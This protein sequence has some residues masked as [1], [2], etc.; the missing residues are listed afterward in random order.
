MDEVKALLE[1]AR[2]S[3]DQDDYAT[4]KDLATPR[5]TAR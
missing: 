5:D 2:A 1:R 4:L 3:M